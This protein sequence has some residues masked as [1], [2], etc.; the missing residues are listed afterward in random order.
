M[1][2]WVN[3]IATIGVVMFFVFFTWVKIGLPLWN[4]FKKQQIPIQPYDKKRRKIINAK[5]GIDWKIE[6]GKIK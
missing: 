3:T 2:S 6:D 5:E 4:D 1:S